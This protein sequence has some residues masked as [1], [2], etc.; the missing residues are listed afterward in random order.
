[1]FSPAQG[2]PVHISVLPSHLPIY[3]RQC[4]VEKDSLVTFTMPSRD[5]FL[6][7]GRIRSLQIDSTTETPF[8]VELVKELEDLRKFSLNLVGTLRLLVLPAIEV[9]TY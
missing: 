7:R 4:V 2:F 3:M 8:S 5:T 1:M 9:Y 6:S